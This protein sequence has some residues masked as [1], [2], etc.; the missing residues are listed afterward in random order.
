M[1]NYVTNKKMRKR[2]L[3]DYDAYPHHPCPLEFLLSDIEN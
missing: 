2:F 1:K 3:I